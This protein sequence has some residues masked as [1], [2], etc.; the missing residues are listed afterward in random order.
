MSR[1]VKIKK[2]KIPETPREV[3]ERAHSLGMT[4]REYVDHL[5]QLNRDHKG[6][7]NN[8]A[9]YNMGP[10]PWKTKTGSYKRKGSK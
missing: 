4:A 5:A 10:E 2:P 8:R 1:R 6:K 9:T 3:L 7:R